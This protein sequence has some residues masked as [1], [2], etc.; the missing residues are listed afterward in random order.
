MTLMVS[1]RVLDIST[2]TEEDFTTRSGSKKQ[3]DQRKKLSS[4]TNNVSSKPIKCADPPHDRKN[5]SQT[6]LVYVGRL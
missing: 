6:H 1:P 3:N 4:D 2:T 5:N